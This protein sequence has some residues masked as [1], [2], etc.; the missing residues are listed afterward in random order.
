MMTMMIASRCGVPVAVQILSNLCHTFPNQR[1][2]IITHSNQALN[3]VFE[4][5]LLRDVDERY[6]LRLGHG[7]ELLETEKDFS[8]AGT[9]TQGPQPCSTSHQLLG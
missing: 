2:L 9:P 4:K 8:R 7:E 5:L 3:D 1:L 6:L